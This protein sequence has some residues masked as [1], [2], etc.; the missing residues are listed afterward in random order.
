MPSENNDYIFVDDPTNNQVSAVKLTGGRYSNVIYRYGNIRFNEDA[1]NDT[2]T[3]SY[4]YK[5]I[6]KP[7][8]LG[9]ID[10]DEDASFKNYIGDILN[11]ILSNN[12]FKIGDNGE[13]S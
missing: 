10:L 1:V 6:Y 2:C 11:D 12:E 5:I 4:A 8:N 7:E 3:L 13:Q 9:T